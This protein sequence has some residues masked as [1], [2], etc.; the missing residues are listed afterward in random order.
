MSNEE[1]EKAIADKTA[2]L[3]KRCFSDEEIYA[4]IEGFRAGVEWLKGITE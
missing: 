3:E 4:Y 1:L 2:E